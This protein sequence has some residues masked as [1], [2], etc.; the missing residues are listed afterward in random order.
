MGRRSSIGHLM[1]QRTVTLLTA[2]LLLS[3]GVSE[4][5]RPAPA[6]ATPPG[7][8][9]PGPAPGVSTPP[10]TPPG[11]ASRP[12]TKL[13]ASP[14][15]PSPADAGA[16]RSMPDAA[17]PGTPAPPTST[18]GVTIG[19][20]FVPRER[21]LVVLH[22][23]HSNMAG[24]AT[25]PIELKPYFYDLDPQLWT[26][27]KGGLFK[28]ATE[29]TAPDNQDGQAAGPGMALLHTAASLAAPGS[30]VI[31]IGHGHSGSFSGYCSNFR[32]GGLFYD[33]VMQAAMELKGK[34]TFV[35]I[36]TMFGQS[37]HNATAAMQ[38]AFGDCMMG[39]AADMRG[40]LGEPDLPFVMGDYEANL[41]KPGIEPT[42][43]FGKAI[44]TQL[45][46]LPGKMNHAA[47]IP[48]DGLPMQD[49]HHYNMAGHKEWAA[50]GFQLLREHGWAP[51]VVAA[52]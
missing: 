44:I 12:D 48:T 8:A 32:K 35:G 50:R 33:I 1:N 11:P 4:I 45:R 14:G 7:P 27:A 20:K 5:D 15:A 17:A 40:D 6:I 46:A 34:V 47:L 37:E 52:P 23:G 13:D 10:E 39:V 36:F 2:L 51:W 21:A 49:D 41:T 26:Y 30:Y 9:T 29:P 3:C 31:S 38:S 16:P 24:R 22:I 28:Q 18:V 42:S 25:G 19:G 43:P